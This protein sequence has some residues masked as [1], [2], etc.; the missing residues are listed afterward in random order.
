VTGGCSLSSR[1]QIALCE[2]LARHFVQN[3]LGT[4][5][6]NA[7]CVRRRLESLWWCLTLWMIGLLVV[8]RMWT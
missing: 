7:T 5:A 3:G 2:R 6:G 4:A 8:Q 1:R